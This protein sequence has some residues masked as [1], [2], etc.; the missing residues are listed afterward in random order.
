[1]GNISVPKEDAGILIFPNPVHNELYI[2][3][4]TNIQTV[5]L[6]G[7]DGK[8]IA[9]AKNIITS[10]NTSVNTHNL[11]PGIYFVRV[12]SEKGIATKKFI[13]Q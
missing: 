7:I 12:Q 6:F 13:K 8:Q 1:M 2:S 9:E 5:T 3:T 10:K 11:T 4:K